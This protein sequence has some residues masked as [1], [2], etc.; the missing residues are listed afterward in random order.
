[1]LQKCFIQ[2]GY[3]IKRLKH[4][5]GSLQTKNIFHMSKNYLILK[6][7]IMSRKY[8][9]YVKYAKNVQLWI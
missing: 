3:D 6:N 1:M 8:K 9:M 2:D 5:D 4:Q 7:S